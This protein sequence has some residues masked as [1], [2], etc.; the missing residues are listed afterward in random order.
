MHVIRTS[1]LAR[2]LSNSC[3]DFII[4]QPL[5]M[6]TTSSLCTRTATN[7]AASPPSSGAPSSSSSSYFTS[8][9]G[10]SFSKS[11]ARTRT[12][13]DQGTNDGD[14]LA[15]CRCRPCMHA[16]ENELI[17]YTYME[18]V[19]HM[20]YASSAHVVEDNA[21]GRRIKNFSYCTNK[22]QN[23]GKNT[24]PNINIIPSPSHS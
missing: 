9:S 12:S 19:I 4:F 14:W 7:W 13:F 8:S 2:C 6:S 21:W 17:V 15:C 23:S 16:V 1:V 20:F 22:I 24:P 11:T 10:N 5:L 3:F 18:N